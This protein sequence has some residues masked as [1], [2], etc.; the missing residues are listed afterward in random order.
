VQKPYMEMSGQMILP[1]TLQK[2]RSDIIKAKFFQALFFS[3]FQFQIFL[4]AIYKAQ[5]I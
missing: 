3:L 5:N 2:K 4:G 1:V